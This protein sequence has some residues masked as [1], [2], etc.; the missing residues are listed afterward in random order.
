MVILAANTP[1]STVVIWYDV[2]SNSA[3]A[4]QHN[5]CEP[6]SYVASFLPPTVRQDQLF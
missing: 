4:R 6:K 5:Y 2:G 3:I 1:S